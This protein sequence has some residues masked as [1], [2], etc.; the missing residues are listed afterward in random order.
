MCWKVHQKRWSYNSSRD[1]RFCEAP[2]VKIDVFYIPINI[3]YPCALLCRIIFTIHC[4][5][6]TIPITI[7][8]KIVG[9]ITITPSSSSL[10]SSLPSK[11][12]NPLQLLPG[13]SPNLS[14]S[15]PA[16]SSIWG[17]DDGCNIFGM[18][19]TIY[20]KFCNV[21]S[22]KRWNP[23]ETTLGPHVDIGR[24]AV[25]SSPLDVPGFFLPPGV[26]LLFLSHPY[27]L[28]PLSI[29]YDIQPGYKVVPNRVFAVSL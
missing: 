22:P 13:V 5:P 23:P 18:I 2:S 28:H 24:Q 25:V 15:W 21:C 20:V 3:N 14:G 27:L 1:G 4:F 9:E 26:T 7:A 29:W 12:I 17:N 16:A 19:F 10:I 6:I 8:K 11:P